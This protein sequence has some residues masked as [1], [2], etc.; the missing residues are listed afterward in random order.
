MYLLSTAAKLKN[1]TQFCKS[2]F[3]LGDEKYIKSKVVEI[4]YVYFLFK[5]LMNLIDKVMIIFSF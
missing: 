2:S 4:R 3:V 5:F 1:L